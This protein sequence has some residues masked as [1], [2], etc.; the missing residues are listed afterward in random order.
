[1]LICVQ[2]ELIPPLA[3]VGKR[4]E[5]NSVADLVLR[6]VDRGVALATGKYPSH[7]GTLL[8][9]CG[10]RSVLTRWCS[11]RGGVAGRRPVPAQG[12]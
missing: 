10:C 4:A 9:K 7:L 11:G 8:F 5:A 12:A 1:M 2:T 3:E 6:H